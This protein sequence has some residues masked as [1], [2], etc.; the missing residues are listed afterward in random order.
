MTRINT[1]ISSMTAQKTLGQN[2]S[3][4]QTALTRLSTG[5]RINSGK[6][7]PA[8]LI[9]SE[10]L[11]SDIR[12]TE[13]AI[14]N[15][16][17]ANQMIATADSALGQIG[18]LLIDIRGLATEAANT[19]AVSESQIEANQLQVNSSLDAIDR[20]SQTTQFQGQALLDGSLD[21]QTQGIS[22]SQ[23]TKA[24][25]HQCAFGTAS[26]ID[27][28]VDIESQAT[29]A[30]LTYDNA[31]VTEDTMLS[32]TGSGGNQSIQFGAGSSIND[33]AAAINR[34]S[35][36]TGVTATAEGVQEWD[37]A[38]GQVT[39]QSWG[40]N[41]DIT[42]TANDTGEASGSYFVNY[43]AGAD[44]DATTAT[45]TE[46]TVDAEGNVTAG[47]INVTLGTSAG[48][49][50]ATANYT[51][52]TAGTAD[53]G[54][55]AGAT[56]FGGTSDDL[57]WTANGVGEGTVEGPTVKFVDAG[58]GGAT[59][60]TYDANNNT[61]Y[62]SWDWINNDIDSDDVAGGFTGAGGALHTFAA[63]TDDETANK[64]A[65]SVASGAVTAGTN[66]FEAGNSFTVAANST[67]A[68]V[69]PMKVVVIDG[70]GDAAYDE[71]TN[72]YSVQLDISGG[73]TT[74]AA[75]A[76]AT[77]LTNLGNAAH[78][79]TD[80]GGGG[81]LVVTSA[82][83]TVATGFEVTAT[84]TQVGTDTVSAGTLTATANDVIDAINTAQDAIA[85]GDASA[86]LFDV[87]SAAGNDGTGLVALS[88]VSALVGDNPGEQPDA[89]NMLQFQA[90]DG[91]RD[92]S[93][94]ASAPN[95][96]LSIDLNSAAPE[97]AQA[98][99][100][101]DT[102]LANGTFELYALDPGAAGN[103]TIDIAWTDAG[104]AGSGN[105]VTLAGG[106]LTLDVEQDATINDVIDAINAE[107]GLGIGARLVEADP[108]AGTGT[109]GDGTETVNTIAD[110]LK[111]NDV[112]TDLTGGV[113]DEGTMIINLATDAAGNVT[114]TANELAT[115]INGSTEQALQD[116]QVMVTNAG[117]S[118]GTGALSA[119]ATDVKFD[120]A[121][122]T[123]A[124]ANATATTHAANGSAAQIDIT[125]KTEG[126]AYDGVT[127][128][129]VQDTALD[130]GAVAVAFSEDSNTLLV[131]FDGTVS[132]E[133]AAA[134]INTD[135]TVGALFEAV[136]TAGEGSGSGAIAD[137]DFGVLSGGTT[138]T[139]VSGAPELELIGGV[140]AGTSTDDAI[141]TFSSA[142]YGSDAFVDVQAVGESNFAVTDSDGNTVTRDSG[143]DIVA[144]I[145]GMS[146]VGTG[147]DAELNSSSIQ[148]SL[149]INENAQAGDEFSFSITGGGATFQLGPEIVSNQQARLGIQSVSSTSLGGDDGHGFLYQLR[150]GEAADLS[151]D[152]SGAATIVNDCIDQVN[153]LRGRLGAF[154]ATT[155]DVNIATLSDTVEAL[156]EAESSI[157][158][159]DFA[160]ESA[161]LT[162]AQILSQST[163]TVLGIAKQQPNNVLSL[164]R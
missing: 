14:S 126:S 150:S 68:E 6:D 15:S 104:A 42:I 101:I 105:T 121:G 73:T 21:F 106:T 56:L 49:G 40:D 88:E 19:G 99:A 139:A 127:V 96:E 138:R 37:A 147:L 82:G 75:D 123:Y 145:N 137:G 1:N 151:A 46:S 60:Y 136:A 116:F 2:N 57:T 87:T 33:M 7:D 30:E 149:S 143:T 78:T 50:A 79:F 45:I 134:A 129:M 91:M 162:R 65:L 155:L 125:A 113:V 89:N 146:S 44:G 43:T 16:E 3:D 94:V 71:T 9:A 117:G 142:S 115:F 86:Y 118:D 4:M 153:N 70:T 163:T 67:G 157:R 160:K 128:R 119:T 38:A 95:Q 41:N 130:D 158:D 36:A 77:T 148:I 28:A 144:R 17:R 164:L 63:G 92:I 98:S 112:S 59:A 141:L 26:Q 5:L 124:D 24:E 66:G 27:I 52:N 55:I 10:T 20:I 81:N 35:D 109:V 135:E 62:A 156:T 161:N 76:L 61:Y 110:G 51:M 114:T 54:T 100:V 13:V 39:V 111:V 58:D 18:S 140:D 23:I 22:S 11:R 72:T 131:T 108:E 53:S 93:L 34:V 31:T 74:L 69:A 102:G 132:A 133:T 120:P 159:A 83:S 32:I 103:Q 25:I 152:P 80:A 12:A 64:A 107:T 47:T 122:T 97:Y 84:N 154:Q 85:G 90:L 29:K 8:G 48:V